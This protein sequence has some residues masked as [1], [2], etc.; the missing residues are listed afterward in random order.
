MVLGFSLNIKSM[1]K[2]KKYFHSLID[3]NCNIYFIFD[4]IMYI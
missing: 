1:F 2:Y 3:L 4:S